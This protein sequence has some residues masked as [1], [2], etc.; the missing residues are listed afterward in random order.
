MELKSYDKPWLPAFKGAFLI[1]LGI[2]AMLRI[3]GTV[4]ALAALFIALIGM[5]SI[6]LIGTG[7]LFKKSKFRGWTIVSGVINLL[8]CFYIA[9]HIDSPRN[10]V[11][12]IILIWVLFY[13]V[14][15]AIEAGLLLSQKNAFSALFLL[16]AFLTLLFGYFLYILLG[17]F[18]EQAV[19][20][21][22]MIA[23]VFGIANELSAFL[24]SR[25]QEKS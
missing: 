15:E 1:L 5:I 6:L 16:N 20:Y 7:I 24:L 18:T 9:F 25:I 17:N 4:K 3:F 22:G 13:A 10:G 8:F 14:S 12:W 21:V 23:F 19:F 2:I 11:L